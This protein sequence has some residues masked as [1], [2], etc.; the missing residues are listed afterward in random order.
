[1]ISLTQVTEPYQID[2]PAGVTLTVKPLTHVLYLQATRQAQRDVADQM[3]DDLQRDSAEHAARLQAATTIALARLAVT[4]WTGV[5]G[6]DDQPA[7]CTPDS[8]RQLLESHW[9]LAEN[10]SQKY[11]GQTELLAAEKKPLAGSSAG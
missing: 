7:P 5:V 3:T 10:F 9:I 2:L 11:N 6:E 4:D 8:V 1:M